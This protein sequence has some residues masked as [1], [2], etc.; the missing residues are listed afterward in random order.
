MLPDREDAGAGIPVPRTS[1]SGRPSMESW[2]TSWTPAAD[3]SAVQA[4]RSPSLAAVLVHQAA[5]IG[6]AVRSA[7]G[8]PSH[9]ATAATGGERRL[10]AP[11]RARIDP[12]APHAVPAQRLMQCM[13][14]RSSHGQQVTRTS[15]SGRCTT[16]KAQRSPSPRPAQPVPGRAACASPCCS[17]CTPRRSSRCP[18]APSASA[19]TPSRP[20]SP[21]GWSRGSPRSWSWWRRWGPWQRRWLVHAAR[22]LL[23]VVTTPHPSTRGSTQQS[24][25][26]GAA[27]PAC[28]PSPRP[29]PCRRPSTQPTFCAG[30]AC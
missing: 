11:G 15:R 27:V 30:W 5:A 18:T 13:M 1:T 4:A 24:R 22:Q 8:I 12:A 21:Q 25:V 14:Q 29:P 17:T 9:Q 2:P 3:W 6:S 23:C 20:A 10:W 7:S 16:T 19:A 26:A 28:R